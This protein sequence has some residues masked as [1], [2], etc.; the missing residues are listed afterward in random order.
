MEPSPQ[1]RERILTQSRR[2][3]HQRGSGSEPRKQASTQS[4]M[5]EFPQGRRAWTVWRLAAIAAV[6]LFA[7][8]DYLGGSVVAGKPDAAPRTDEFT[9]NSS[10]RD[11][12]ARS[13]ELSR[14]PEQN[15]SKGDRVVRQ[16][17]WSAPV[18]SSFTTREVARCSW[19]QP[20]FH[21]R[22]KARNINSGTSSVTNRHFRARRS[23]PT[24]AGKGVVG[25]VPDAHATR[26]VRN[27]ARARRRRERSDRRNLPSQRTVNPIR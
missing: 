2:S 17:D 12:L 9:L 14:H 22:P 8:V 23:R 13:N 3:H 16:W 7:R 6:V 21:A 11:R 15:R 5:V 25:S 24:A 19:S 18:R 27:H 20:D 10:N 4:R 1:V 26:R